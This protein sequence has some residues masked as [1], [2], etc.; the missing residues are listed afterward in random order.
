MAFQRSSGQRLSRQITVYSVLCIV[1]TF[2]TVML[3]AVWLSRSHDRQAAAV[4]RSSAE[5]I[6]RTAADR[7]AEAAGN[8]ANRREI[9]EAYRT[10]DRE[11]LAE[12]FGA[13]LYG[14]PVDASALV[15]P[16]GRVVLSWREQ[17]RQAPLGD[18][19][20][21]ALNLLASE[22]ETGRGRTGFARS[23]D[24]VMLV[25]AARIIGGANAPFSL[26]RPFLM[27][28]Q[29][30]GDEISS[31]G[32]SFSMPSLKLADTSTPG[33]E[34]LPVRDPSGQVLGFLS[35]EAPQPGMAILMEGYQFLLFALA[36]FCVTMF[37]ISYRTRMLGVALA[38]SEQGAQKAARTDGL[39]GLL[40]RRGFLEFITSEEAEKAA[41]SGN[42]AVI[43]LDINGF[44]RV[45]DAVGHSGGDDMIRLISSRFA[46]AQPAGAT[47]ARLGS[48]EFAMVVNQSVAS[49]VS[50][51]ALRLTSSLSDPLT[52]GGLEFQVSCAVGFALASAE[53]NEPQTL[54][55]QADT[56]MFQAKRIAR[57]EPL[58]FR[59][60]MDTGTQDKKNLE[61]RLRQALR[62]GELEVYYQPIARASDGAVAGLEALI[63]W[64]GGM[65]SSSPIKMISVAEESGLIREIGDFVLERVCE[66]LVRWPD[67]RVSVNVSPVQLRD[68]SFI[69]NFRAVLARHRV[70]PSRLEV[71]LTEGILISD[72]AMA[73]KKLAQ[74]RRLG[75]TIALDDFGTGYSSIGYLRSYSFDRLKIDRS[76]TNELLRDPQ[77]EN[78]VLSVLA[79]AAAMNLPVVAEGVENAQQFERLAGAGCEFVQG[80]FIQRPGSAAAIEA[81]L[82]SQAVAVAPVSTDGK[83]VR[84][85]RT[86][87]VSRR[88]VGE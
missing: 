62:N 35:W 69:S 47:L 80:Y 19:V 61:G 30:L 51:A 56:A 84:L 75:V 54:V 87:A 73:S 70:P 3:T 16:T 36:A 33:K 18:A 32:R 20:T 60:S 88:L 71:E 17:E 67:L 14:R 79:V 66:D 83:V 38:E 37:G 41:R 82:Q 4:S 55:R 9:D 77:G 45:N 81:F 76:L 74:L 64:P 65:G 57:Q 23:G 42:L 10:E 59:P 40:N 52:V 27:A 22:H 63:R 5:G 12:Q 34:N 78:L 43:F 85:G 7:L 50:E 48:D 2:L 72:P 21:T 26:D 29:D 86:R 49:R 39:T 53:T 6:L 8:V 15:T 68:P 11:T 13:G 1:V 25:A 44:K 28:V 46:A 24:R 58:Q 31:L